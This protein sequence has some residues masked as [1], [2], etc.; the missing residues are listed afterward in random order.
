V[1]SGRL[2]KHWVQLYGLATCA[3]PFT[4]PAIR[5]EML[6]HRRLDNQPAHVW[7]RGMMQQ[8]ASQVDYPSAA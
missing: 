7:L 2:A 6:W 3:L 1:L 4:S 5:T 8:T